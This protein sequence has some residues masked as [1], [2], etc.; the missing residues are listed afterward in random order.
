MIEILFR[1][2]VK[3]TERSV[4]IDFIEWDVRVA[5]ED[6]RGSG[7]LWFDYYEDPEDRNAF[8]VYEA[9]QNE[10]AFDAHKRNAPFKRWE[11]YIK[12]NVLTEFQILFE[13]GKVVCSSKTLMPH[14][15]AALKSLN[16]QFAVMEQQRDAEAKAW[17]DT[18]LSDHLIFRRANESMV[19]KRSFLKGL[20]YPSPFARRHME[21]VHIIVLVDRVFVLL[22]VCTTKADGTANRYRNIRLFSKAAQ[23]WKLDR[24]WNYDITNV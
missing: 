7:T 11:A 22:L 13:S 12:Q 1:A 15:E 24:W 16:E 4:F 18:I 19:D 6:E 5:K 8:F 20:D 23:S 3:A 2:E 9:Y 17:F 14:E 10:A 21:D